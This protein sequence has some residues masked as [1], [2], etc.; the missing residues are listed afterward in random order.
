M[1]AA[2]MKSTATI[3]LFLAVTVTTRAHGPVA[4]MPTP[5]PWQVGPACGPN[6]LYCL[7]RIRNVGVDYS[8]LLRYLSPPDEGNS[9]EELRRAAAHWGLELRVYKLGKHQIGE[10]EEPFI[11]H[12]TD[13]GASHHALVVGQDGLGVRIWDPERAHESI[14][15]M[16]KFARIWSGYVLALGVRNRSFWVSAIAFSFA[17]LGVGISVRLASYHSRLKHRITTGLV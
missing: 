1:S 15:P 4:D 11:A 5:D 17:L 9:L 2:R 7:L 16:P 14:V 3:F 6:A 10:I 13:Q 8:A 12:I